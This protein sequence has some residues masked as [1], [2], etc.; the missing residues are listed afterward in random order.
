MPCPQVYHEIHV[1]TL[2]LARLYASCY[3][4]ANIR[5]TKKAGELPLRAAA[6][7]MGS[8]GCYSGGGGNL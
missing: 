6:V 4:I 3:T 1:T 8:S 5:S 2:N 7:R